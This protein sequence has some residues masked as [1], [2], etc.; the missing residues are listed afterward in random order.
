M[1]HEPDM[2]P[3]VRPGPFPGAGAGPRKSRR[4]RV[5]IR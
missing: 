2:L 1:M 5:V 4:E 3:A